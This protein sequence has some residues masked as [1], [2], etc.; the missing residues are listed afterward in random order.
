VEEGAIA[1]IEWGDLS[2][3][4]LGDDALDITLTL[5]DTAA[6]SHRTLSIS[7]RGRWAGRSDE[8][9]RA[10]SSAPAGAAS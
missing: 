10:L 4:A 6:L 7:G 9:A 8:V 2:A 3:A 5:P 1:L